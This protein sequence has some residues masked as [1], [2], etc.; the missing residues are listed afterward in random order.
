MNAPLPLPPFNPFADVAV[1]N[2]WKSKE[3]DVETINSEAYKGLLGL[4]RQL[5]ATPNLAALVLGA[6]GSGKTHLIKRLIS[7]HDVEAVFVYVHPLRDHNRIFTSLMEH[8]ASNLTARP[9]WLSDSEHVTQLDLV[10]ANV[11]AAA[12]DNYLAQNPE[13]RGRTFLRTIKKWPLKILSFSSS[14]KWLAFLHNTYEFLKRKS[15]LGAPM[16]KRVLKAIF[17]YVEEPK[18]DAVATFL[19]GTIPD[20]RECSALN[21]EF[22]EGDWTIEAQEQRSKEVLKAIGGLLEFYRPM[23]LCFDQLD[24]LESPQLVRAVGT[25]FMDIV[26]ETEHILPVGFV[27]PEN[28]YERFKKILD[29]AAE[30][31]MASNAFSL[32]GCNLKQALQLIESRLAWAYDGVQSRPLDSFFP[33]DRVTLQAR[34]RGITSPREIITVASPLFLK[35][36]AVSVENPLEVVRAAF[37]TERESILALTEQEPARQDTM[38]AALKLCFEN[39]RARKGRNCAVVDCSNETVKLAI[40]SEKE[41]TSEKTAILRVETAAHWR[42]LTKVF[43]KLSESLNSKAA[44]FSIVLRDERTPIPPKKGAMPKTV[45]KLTEFEAVGGKLIYIDYES[46]ADLYA[47]VYTEDKVNAGDLSYIAYPEG[48]RKEV[49]HAVLATYVREEFPSKLLDQL[50]HCLLG[51][52]IAKGGGGVEASEEEIIQAM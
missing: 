15:S 22:S 33:L 14:P 37:T 49:E 26:N 34:L 45:E 50:V 41:S 44:D 23:V 31:R 43:A 12:F 52:P 18:R 40:R 25:L 9:P 47:L 51:A 24:S 30:Q 42:P 2:P 29:P 36:P 20:E 11:I 1:G 4:I 38:V 46:L 32:T 39:F 5:G 8:V 10:I 16:S 3:P 35:E 13:D 7:G 17:Q 48:L 27:R 19:S 28:W 6:A 21:L